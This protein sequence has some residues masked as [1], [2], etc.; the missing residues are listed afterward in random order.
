MI[1]NVSLIVLAIVVLVGLPVNAQEH[2]CHSHEH[3][4]ASDACKM[5]TGD[6]K[7]V[8]MPDKVVDLNYAKCP[9]MGGKPS[10]EVV[11]L[12][13]GRIYHFCCPGCIS[14]FKNDPESIIA[15]IGET[16]EKELKI[17]NKAKKCPV[18][19]EIARGDVYRVVGDKI[20]FYCCPSCI[21]K[22]DLKLK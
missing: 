17:G 13:N 19:G 20:T 18:T 16:T 3:G 4:K 2:S 15:K 8:E 1:K 6:E 14:A 22:D 21:G 10:A 7:L 11:A 12:K 9:V 5:K